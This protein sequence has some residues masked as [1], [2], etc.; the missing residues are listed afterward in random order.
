MLEWQGMVV[1]GVG[2][3]ILEQVGQELVVKE[4]MEVMVAEQVVLLLEAVVEDQLLLELPLEQMDQGREERELHQVFQDRHY[5]MLLEVEEEMLT[6]LVLL[7][8]EDLALEEMVAK[9][10]TARTQQPIEVLEVVVE[11][12]IR[13]MEEMVVME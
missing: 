13:V 5:F 1:L 4:T 3:F 9:Q 11:E 12:I 2:L 8:M 10:V 6:Q 7:E